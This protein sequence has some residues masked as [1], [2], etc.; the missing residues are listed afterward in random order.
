VVEV[1][2]RDEERRGREGCATGDESFGCS[3]ADK[4]LVG[5]PRREAKGVI[6]EEWVVQER[7]EEGSVGGIDMGEEYADGKIAGKRVGRVNPLVRSGEETVIGREIEEIEWVNVE[8]FDSGGGRRALE[9]YADEGKDMRGVR[10]GPER[11]IA[12]RVCIEGWGGR[13]E[14]DDVIGR[15]IRSPVVGPRGK[16]D[17]DLRTGGREGLVVF[18]AADGDIEGRNGKTGWGFEED[19]GIECEVP[20]VIDKCMG[21]DRGG[22]NERRVG[23]EG[24]EGVILERGPRASGDEALGDGSREKSGRN[25]ED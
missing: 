9:F 17:E 5:G 13:S 2:T 3:L 20:T 15:P 14:E 22:D 24:F 19:D 23:R 7:I 10:E 1:G 11:E 21:T 18:V 12:N 8:A 6:G 25:E 4:V 16:E